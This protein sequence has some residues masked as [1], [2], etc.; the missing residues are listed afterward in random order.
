MHACDGLDDIPSPYRTLSPAIAGIMVATVKVR[1]KEALM[2]QFG[3]S[4]NTWRKIEANEPLRSSL[5][6]RIEKRLRS[7]HR[8]Q[9]SDFAD[10]DHA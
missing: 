1:T 8:T 3:I 9:F 4:Y 7:T 2:A 5:A 6:D 10:A